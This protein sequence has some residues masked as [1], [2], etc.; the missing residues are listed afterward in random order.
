MALKCHIRHYL[1]AISE[2]YHTSEQPQI[3]MLEY[4]SFTLDMGLADTYPEYFMNIAVKCK[5]MPSIDDIMI[6]IKIF[7]CYKNIFHDN[8][9]SIQK[10]KSVFRFMTTFMKYSG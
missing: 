3:F 7:R 2:Y 1:K 9:T 8:H 4:I 6:L 5:I 10:K